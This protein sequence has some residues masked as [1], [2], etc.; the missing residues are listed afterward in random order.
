[1]VEVRPN[2]NFDIS[3]QESV[4]EAIICFLDSSDYES[5][6]RSSISIGSD[7]D[8]IACIAGGIAQ[9]YYEF[10]P[11]DLVAGAREK[12]PAEMIGI[13][14]E[15]ERMGRTFNFDNRTHIYKNKLS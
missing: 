9:A 1:V 8:T 11:P 6:I 14:D 13:S 15:F 4:P 10:L 7:S 12:S 3:C 2:Y 5:C